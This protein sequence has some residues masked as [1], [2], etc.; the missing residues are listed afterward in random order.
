MKRR[1]SFLPAN[2]LFTSLLFFTWLQVGK[3]DV[4][5]EREEK[6]KKKNKKILVGYLKHKLYIKADSTND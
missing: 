1:R 3:E 5:L 6:M 4:K 2:I